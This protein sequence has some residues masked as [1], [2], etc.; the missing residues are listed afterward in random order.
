MAMTDLVQTTKTLLTGAGLGEKPVIVRAASDAS[1]T[2]TGAT[3]VFNLLAG[4]GAGSGIKP[5]DILSVRGAATQALSAV[6]Y[7]LSVST[8]AI[9]ALNSYDGAPATAANALDAA[10][11]ELNAP[12]SEFLLWAD[13]SSVISGLLWPEVYL[14]TTETIS[15]P[16]LANFQ[17]DLASGTERI[18][19][20]MQVIGGENYNISH[21]IHTN[22]HSTVASTNVY[23]E[24]YVVDGSA[25][26][27]SAVGRVLEGS[28][29]NFSLSQCIATGAA[30]LAAGS[31]LGGGSLES[32]S[33]D[34]QQR[35]QLS[36]RQ[37]LWQDFVALRSSLAQDLSMEEGYFS[38][39][40]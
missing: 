3:I 37:A 40:L 4:E 2:I 34:S 19:H 22:V 18:V 31:M 14:Y 7:V 8:D 21:Q 36:P 12:R 28:T 15:S 32:S 16:D 5:G 26:Y 13:V 24:L 6:L 39:V 11:F 1:E 20:V 9:T 27:V 17:N 23:A 33:K 25:A 30:A 29:H 38:V 10:V 35:V